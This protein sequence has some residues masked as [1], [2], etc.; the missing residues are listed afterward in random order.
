MFRLPLLGCL[1]LQ[2]C[3]EYSKWGLQFAW[4]ENSYLYDEAEYFGTFH[5]QRKTL[6]HPFAGTP[7]HD[8]RAGVHIHWL[9]QNAGKAFS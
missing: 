5:D 6:N 7:E 2:A 8:L 1:K 3:K 9:E 4:Q